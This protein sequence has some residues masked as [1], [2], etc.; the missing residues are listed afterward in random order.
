MRL[1][2]RRGRKPFSLD[3]EPGF[4]GIEAF[5]PGHVL[6]RKDEGRL[7]D[8]YDLVH[9]AK[10]RSDRTVSVAQLARIHPIKATPDRRQRG[11]ATYANYHNVVARLVAFGRTI[12]IEIVTEVANDSLVVSSAV[13]RLFSKAATERRPVEAVQTK[14]RIPNPWHA[15]ARVNALLD[16]LSAGSSDEDDEAE[17]EANHAQHEGEVAHVH[18]A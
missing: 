9:F 7:L 12:G 10:A 8:L 4:Y 17:E 1:R 16:A 13:H 3:D 14:I 15:A 6:S 18:E 11:G 5:L 2:L